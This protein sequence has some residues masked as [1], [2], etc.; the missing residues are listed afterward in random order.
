MYTRGPSI[1]YVVSRG[2]GEGSKIA[3]FETTVYGQPLGALSLLDFQ[4]FKLAV[5]FLVSADKRS[6]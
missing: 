6:F 5:R 4:L 1:N 2:K 3:D